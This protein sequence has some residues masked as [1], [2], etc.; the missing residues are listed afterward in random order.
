ME[1]ELPDIFE[2]FDRMASIDLLGKT[3]EVPDNN[4]ILR[5]FQYLAMESVSESDLCWN[6]D[7]MNCQVWIQNG[8]KEK[9]LIACRAKVEDGMRILRV[10]DDIDLSS[11]E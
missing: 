1:I 3:V 8:E 4:T 9:T 7:C 2:P 6:S 5:C 11:M 10:S